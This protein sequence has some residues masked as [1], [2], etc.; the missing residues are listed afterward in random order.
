MDQITNRPKLELT[1]NNFK[2]LS[3]ASI[4][5][6][7]FDDLQRSTAIIQHLSNSYYPV[8]FILN[9]NF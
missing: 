3:R 8:K 7:W 1:Q 5:S 6:T 4:F 2:D 9:V